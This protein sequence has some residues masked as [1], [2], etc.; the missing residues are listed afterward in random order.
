ME[1]PNVGAGFRL[2]RHAVTVV[3]R[4]MVKLTPPENNVFKPHRLLVEWS[5]AHCS[6]VALRQLGLYLYRAGCQWRCDPVG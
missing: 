1:M 4:I 2:K 6:S 3:E 5:G